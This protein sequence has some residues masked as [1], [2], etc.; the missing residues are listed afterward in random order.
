MNSIQLLAV[1]GQTLRGE[2]PL[3]A[4]F[5]ALDTARMQDPTAVAEFMREVEALYSK[6]EIRY[7][8]YLT[9][10]D[11]VAAANRPGGTQRGASATGTYP[12]VPSGQR[13]TTPGARTPGTSGQPVTPSSTQ[14][15]THPAAAATAAAASAPL[16]GATQLR[17]AR[18]AKA[19]AA[20][21][22]D[23]RT[24]LRNPTQAPVEA[25]A[26]STGSTTSQWDEGS[27]TQTAEQP[28]E[29]GTL[30][31]GRFLLEERV[32]SGG[33]GV[34]FKARD[35][36]KEE[37]Q[38]R[39]PYV[40]IKFLNAEFR[41]HPESLKSLQRE[42]RRSQ[43]LAHPN[44]VNVYDF[45]RDGTL[46]FMT[47]EFLEGEPL[48]RFIQ[49]HPQGLRFNEAWPLIEGL[50]RAL[51]YA[52]EQGV[53]HADFKPG[54]VFVSDGKAKV[55]DFG[56]AR[57]M[58]AQTDDFDA[59]SLGALT[60]AYASP[61][62]F[63]QGNPDPRDDIYAL[64][65]VAYE[66]MTGRHPFNGATAIKAAHE[67]MKVK[68]AAGM[69]RYQYK[70]LLHG[71]AFKQADRTP[72]VAAFLDEIAGLFGVRGRAIRQAVV[73][74][75]STAVLVS[76]VAV[77]VW[78]FTRPDPDKQLAQRVVEAATVQIQ[79]LE[80][81]GKL[82]EDDPELRAVLLEQGNDY[83][84]MGRTLFDPGVL[85]EGVSNAYGAFQ[86]VLRMDPQDKQAVAGIVAIVG[87]Y[88]AEIQRRVL[89]AD[90]AGVVE[91]AGYARKIDPN[92]ASFEDAE[93]EAR[94]HVAPATTP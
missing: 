52:H 43:Y 63:L 68:R 5:S 21:N 46:I 62:M 24:R 53:I 49:R 44:V 91:L 10:R 1:L 48:D 41:S 69:G 70:A 67:G 76:V 34:V 36:R 29:P 88:E 64:A 79:E 37:A 54:N 39:D 80:R 17:P 11:R 75:A 42:T 31:K 33:M 13:I 8:V 82:L 16:D 4:M 25:D 89:A 6:N 94:K 22:F 73:S 59:G 23:D 50:G 55:L 56:I 28:L 40:A 72:S 27:W 20:E 38:D 93:R 57:A 71:L 92:R 83:L 51:Q 61:E 47:M 87:L 78:W 18:V 26:A 85:S 74:T 32:G 12:Q 66:I 15:P 84:E 90:H 81:T 14:A 77:A 65:V 19:P 2:A 9:L 60:P 7:D 86:E 30:I 35:L 45:D 3:E 58:K